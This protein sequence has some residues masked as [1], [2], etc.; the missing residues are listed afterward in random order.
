MLLRMMRT[1]TKRAHSSRRAARALARLRREIADRLSVRSAVPDAVAVAGRRYN[2]F[3]LSI[4]PIA[5]GVL[6]YGGAAAFYG[7]S[8]ETFY[9]AV[10]ATIFP[11]CAL[12]WASRR[13]DATQRR[14]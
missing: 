9:A 14:A 13:V 6:A 10:S 4:A 2:I 7:W 12:Q 5:M 3:Q 1:R 8:E 11:F